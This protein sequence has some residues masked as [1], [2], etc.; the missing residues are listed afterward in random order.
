MCGRVWQSITRAAL[1]RLFGVDVQV[2]L[3]PRYNL[4]PTQPMLL[5]REQDGRQAVQARW[6]LLANLDQPKSLSTFNARIETVRTS[7]LFR[8]AFRSRRALIPITGLYEWTGEKN[9]RRPVAL[10]RRDDKPL[11]CAGL[12]TELEGVL[13]CTVL[14]T[15]PLG[16]LAGPGERTGPRLVAGHPAAR[17]A[18]GGARLPGE[19]GGR[20][21]PKRGRRA[22]VSSRLKAE[23]RVVRIRAV[24]HLFPGF[25]GVPRPVVSGTQRQGEG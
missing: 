12:W 21:R 9:Q 7:P 20:Q 19:P 22:D 2:P 11:V 3:L 17:P 6:G 18:H 5:V 8:E 14:T 13:S 1:K 23:L 4:A 24:A 16:R 10:K 25:P 15:T